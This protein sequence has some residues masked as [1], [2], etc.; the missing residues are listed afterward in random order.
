MRHNTVFYKVQCALLFKEN[1]DEN[2][3][4]ALYLEGS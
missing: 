2:I 1:G 3:A 4:C